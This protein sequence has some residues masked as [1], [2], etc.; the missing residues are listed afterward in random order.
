MEQSSFLA[1]L[2]KSRN[3][4]KLAAA[5]ESTEVDPAAAA[6]AAAAVAAD[7]RLTC[8]NS[9]P[10]RQTD[11]VITAYLPAGLILFFSMLLCK[12]TSY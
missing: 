2:V 9:Y 7:L 6:A 8:G 1:V 3:I 10:L 11:N 4:T 5:A 12:L